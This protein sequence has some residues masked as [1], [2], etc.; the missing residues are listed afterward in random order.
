MNNVVHIAKS[1]ATDPGY[2]KR[3]STRINAAVRKQDDARLQMAID[4][5]EAKA[6]CKRSG[7]KFKAWVKQEVQ[8]SYSQAAK[9]AKI[10]SS[11]DPEAALAELRKK[12]KDGVKKQRSQKSG[13]RRPPEVSVSRAQYIAHLK[14]QSKDERM[15]EIYRLLDDVGLSVMDFVRVMK[16]RK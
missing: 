13:L 5:A 6:V 4:L 11:D 2:L 3:L 8:L 7:L 9:L 15:N 14:E 12:T 1:Q 16:L 10:G